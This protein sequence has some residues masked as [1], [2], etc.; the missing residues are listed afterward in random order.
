MY[1]VDCGAVINV[2]N[3]QY[4]QNQKIIPKESDGSA[5][6]MH[7]SCL[8]IPQI[9]QDI[10]ASITG[11]NPGSITNRVATANQRA[12][13]MT[14]NNSHACAVLRRGHLKSA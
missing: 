7:T 11:A 8:F 3:F 5:L 14:C 6:S 12:Y 13:S 9:L 1:S 4:L 10:A 2:Q